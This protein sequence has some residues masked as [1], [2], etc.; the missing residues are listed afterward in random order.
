EAGAVIGPAVIAVIG[1]RIIAAPV[2][3]IAAAAI[4]IVPAAVAVAVIVGDARAVIAGAADAEAERHLRRSGR[5][6][7]GGGPRQH[8]G[9][10]RDLGETFHL[11]TPRLAL[12]RNATMNP[13]G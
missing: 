3:G 1:R 11:H 10:Q 5:G 7:Q 4:G 8:H 12:P 6:G 2:I 13:G 9:A